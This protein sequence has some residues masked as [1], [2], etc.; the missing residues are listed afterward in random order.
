MGCV[1]GAAGDAIDEKK[2]KKLAGVEGE[3]SGVCRGCAFDDGRERRP[4]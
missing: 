1:G 2:N 3:P 4:P